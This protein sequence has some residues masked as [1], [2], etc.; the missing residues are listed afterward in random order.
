MQAKDVSNWLEGLY[1]NFNVGEFSRHSQNL[2]VPSK[3]L[4]QMSKGQSQR[5]RLAACLAMD[6]K[7]YLLDEPL[8]GIDLV[9]REVILKTL[10]S[11]KTDQ[12]SI[13]LSTHEIKDVE[14]VFDRALY[15][16]DGNLASDLNASEL[17]TGTKTFLSEFLDVNK[18]S[19][20]P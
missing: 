2:D 11:V 9:S 7:L 16:K 8:S 13:L 15:L 3:R 18:E 5:L 1:P 10:A 6:A 4:S 14:H 12:T 20:V 19:N 17:E